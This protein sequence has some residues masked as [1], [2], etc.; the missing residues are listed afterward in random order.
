MTNITNKTFNLI[1]SL[2]H[3][4]NE[5]II[6]PNYTFHNLD[7]FKFISDKEITDN[8]VAISKRLLHSYHHAIELVP[9]A[10]KSSDIW[11]FIYQKQ[12]KFIS[13]LKRNDPEE[14]AIY[15]NAMHRL[16]ATIGTTQGEYEY[17]NIKYNPLR[18]VFIKRLIKDKLLSLCY[19]IGALPIE[20]PEQGGWGMHASLPADELLFSLKNAIDFDI[21]PP[22][23]D[24]GLFKLV[25]SYG[26]F[27]DRDFTSIYTALLLKNITSDQKDVH[28]CEIGA[29]T[30]RVAYWINRIKPS[31]YT[32][33]DLPHINVLQGYYLLKSSHFEDVTLF[34]ENESYHKPD[35]HSNK[36]SILPN[37]VIG[38][39][40]D[41]HFDLC[42]NQD[43]FPEMD[44]S[45]I[46]NYVNFISRTVKSNFLS[47]N[48]ESPVQTKSF[49]QNS[50]SDLLNCDPNF[51]KIFRNPFW[52]RKGYVEELYSINS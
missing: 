38:S 30:G 42:L 17:F 2:K 33:I 34:G 5:A 49:V 50:V 37:F 25:T 31:R 19:S 10:D 24:G 46:K 41:K 27:H 45:T 12:K 26:F 13:C 6:N 35:V 48:H 32:I 28:F 14:L 21:K 47:I 36:L 4:Q 39:I 40:P 22:D 52:M 29:G 20:N 11:D 3:S 9:A 7:K 23:I 43:S 18:R 15:L 8:D 16:D 1:A 51:N 44:I